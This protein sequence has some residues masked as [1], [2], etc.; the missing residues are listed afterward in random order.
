MLILHEDKS[1]KGTFNHVSKMICQKYISSIEIKTQAKAI[2]G[3]YLIAF[4][5]L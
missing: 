3:H 2:K 5:P 1:G 4:I